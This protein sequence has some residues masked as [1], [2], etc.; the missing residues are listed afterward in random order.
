M[1]TFHVHDFGLP[2]KP[3][4]SGDLPPP[5]C[6]GLIDPRTLEDIDFSIDLTA[7][8][9]Q[10]D[11][12]HTDIIESGGGWDGTKGRKATE[13]TCSCRNGTGPACTECGSK[14]SYYRYVPCFIIISAKQ[15]LITTSSSIAPCNHRTCYNC[16]IKHRVVDDRFNCLVCAAPA[17]FFIFTDETGKLYEHYNAASD[18]ERRD[19]GV[20]VLCKT[21]KIHDD[22]MKKGKR[23]NVGKLG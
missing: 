19:V 1:S 23:D 10:I 4:L 8:N 13:Y 21:V 7:G 17:M 16:A 3:I 18:F 14:S 11:A 2:R 12:R 20:G 15:L 6:S 22:A 9:S 5:L